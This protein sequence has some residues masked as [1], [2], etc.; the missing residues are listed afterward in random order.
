M[1]ASFAHALTVRGSKSTFKMIL[2]HRIPDDFASAVADLPRRSNGRPVSLKPVAEQAAQLAKAFMATTE[3]LTA[4]AARRA[5]RGVSEST[6]E[7]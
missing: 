6:S 5:S 4:E 3:R 1:M 2:A 7:R